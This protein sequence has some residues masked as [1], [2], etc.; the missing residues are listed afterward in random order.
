MGAVEVFIM[1][2]FIAG[3]FDLGLS[4]NIIEELDVFIFLDDGTLVDETDDFADIIV[5]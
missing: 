5:F 2:A 4:E 1:V 3:I